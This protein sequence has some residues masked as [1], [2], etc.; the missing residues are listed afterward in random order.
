MSLERFHQA[1]AGKWAG[2]ATALAEIRA[3]HKR[4]HWIWYAFPQIEGLGR[5]STAREFALRDLNEACDYLR[6]PILRSRYAEIAAAVAEQLAEGIPV[7]LLMGGAADALKLASSV[8]L[9]RAAASRL[10][11]HESDF[12]ALAQICEGILQRTA[13]EGYGPCQFTIERCAE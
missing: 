13:S 9:F 5:S 6:D 12:A 2:Y 8:T 4:S 7:E 3:G 10:A 11:Q 1:Q